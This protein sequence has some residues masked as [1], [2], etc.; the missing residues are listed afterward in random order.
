MPL[1]DLFFQYS[2]NPFLRNYQ[3]FTAMELARINRHDN[4]AN[5]IGERAMLLAIE[6]GLPR[7]IF[8]YLQQGISPNIQNH[9]GWTPLISAINLKEFDAAEA[10]I[11]MGADVS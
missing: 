10:F 5:Y 2:A 1:I 9:V 4:I 8:Y 11:R 7:E 6:I 3:S